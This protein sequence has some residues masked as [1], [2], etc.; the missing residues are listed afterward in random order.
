[1]NRLLSRC[2]HVWLA[3]SWAFLAAARVLAATAESPEPVP[4]T[5]TRQ[6]VGATIPLGGQ[7]ILSV[8]VT[9]TPPVTYQWFKGEEPLTAGTGATLRIQSVKAT[10]AGSYTVVVSNPAGSARSDPAVIAVSLTPIITRQPDPQT[11]DPRGIA[12]FA[13]NATGGSLGYLWLKDG[14]PVPNGRQATLAVENVQEADAGLY[15]VQIANFQGVTTSV[16]VPLT[17]SRTPTA[18]EKQ[19]EILSAG[20]PASEREGNAVS[21]FVRVAG[22][23]PIAIQWLRDDVPIPGAT[24]P[25]FGFIA[26]RT[27]GGT[28]SVLVSNADSSLTRRF[29]PLV[30]SPAGPP[31]DNF[32]DRT[33]IPQPP[34]GTFSTFLASREPDEPVLSER[35]V[36][37]A[38]W[39]YRMPGDGNVTVATENSQIAP[40]LAVFTGTSLPDLQL[41]AQRAATTRPGN[42][43]VTFHGLAD[44]VFSLSVA[45]NFGGHGSYG[46]TVTFTP[47]PPKDQL[48]EITLPPALSGPVT[49]GTNVTLSVTAAGAYPLAYLWLH[50]TQPILGATGPALTLTN[51]QADATG[52]YSVVVSNGN[53]SVT[54]APV[55]LAVQPTAPRLVAGLGT[56]TVTAGYPITLALR[57][58]GS[59]PM[60]FDWT[61]AGQLLPGPRGATLQWRPTRASAPVSVSVVVNSSAGTGSPAPGVVSVVPAGVRYRWT[62][63][64]GVAYQS[65]SADGAGAAARFSSPSGITVDAE[66]TLYVADAGSGR[67]RRVTPEGMVSTLADAVGDP[68]AFTTPVDV[69]LGGDGLLVV[70]NQGSSINRLFG[71]GLV[72]RLGG[73]DWGIGIAPDGA[74]WRTGVTIVE[75]VAADGTIT[76]MAA[77][78]QIVVDVTFDA[79]GNA[80]LAEAT[81]PVIRRLGVDGQLT[82]YAGTPGVSGVDDGPADTAKFQ[83]PNS[84]SFDGAGNLFVADEFANTIRRIA[85]DG[86][87]TTVGGLF[88]R[89]AATDGVGA[90]A[91][92]SNP[93]RVVATRDGT[94]YV[95]D[96]GAHTIRKG[97]P[98]ADTA[99]PRLQAGH[100]GGGVVV[101]WTPG[102]DL[103]WLEHTDSL[104]AA[105]AEWQ[106][107]DPLSD[108]DNPRHL[109]T[110]EE[111]SFYRLRGP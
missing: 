105:P 1:M 82:V 60:T 97:V 27:S 73:G 81:G 62:T 30:I 85:P 38:W 69:A 2:C 21:F 7:V 66:G 47:D 31:N 52:L 88:Q 10:D 58:S 93:R 14:V 5:I 71:D 86:T 111:Q 43:E 108:A 19:L 106:V 35:A 96:T 70:L 59:E 4:P 28:Y 53:G 20:G 91:R 55:E 92:F 34:L 83:H 42:A 44:E 101:S 37:S 33:P 36:R 41:I 110:P 68:L 16:A 46:L 18:E 22:A 84:V 39:T 51:V 80:F 57:P 3:V 94:L 9:A 45:D 13:V 26:Q 54:S 72:A 107:T 61:Y 87:V 90:T 76:R 100:T 48:P 89:V 64:A 75:R 24:K 79:A 109:V 63:L 77:N 103:V 17:L 6:P 67:V 74:M 11:A 65:G 12:T 102:E 23:K 8:T 98:V 104:E 99:A 32:A 49:A 95:T 50:G 40:L 25:D 29:D 56:R 78:L 15:S